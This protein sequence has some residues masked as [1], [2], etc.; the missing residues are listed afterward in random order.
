[1]LHPGV[2]RPIFLHSGVA[3]ECSIQVGDVPLG[4]EMSSLTSHDGRIVLLPLE[5]E[6]EELLEVDEEELDVPDDELLLDDEELEEDE[7]ELEE[8]LDAP[9]DE[10]LVDD[11]LEEDELDELLE[12]V[13]DPLEELEEE[14]LHVAVD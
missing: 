6:D 1:M 11:E 12:V 9:D 5:L 4:H 14:V 7:L 8:E 3:P 13:D 10:L 2:V